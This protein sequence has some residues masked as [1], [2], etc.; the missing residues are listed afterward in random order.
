MTHPWPELVWWNSGERQV[1]E[2]KIHDLER[3]GTICNPK[4]KLLY[5]ALRVTPFR[6]CR[7]AIIGQDPYPSAEMA[8]GVAFS[9]PKDVTA[10]RF[11]QTLRII[12]G[13][14]QSDL[15]YQEPSCGD[16]SAWTRQGALL[17]NAVPSC[18]SGRPLS[19][20]WDEWRYLTGEIAERLNER[21]GTVF[22]FLGTVAASYSDKINLDTNRVIKTS[23]PSPRG[24]Q[25]GKTPFTGSR[26]FSTINAKLKEL[27]LQPI[28]WELTDEPPRKGNI[29]TAVV[30]RGRVLPNIT[31]AQLGGLK[32]TATSPNI[33]TSLA[34]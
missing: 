24:N 14:L 34:F 31:G 15:H 28:S 6:D 12:L 30:D 21:G 18:Q 32:R 27:D 26:V 33:Y 9:I 4:R 25:F 2:E 17:W 5:E 8:T 10:E 23:H 20:N 13:E 7:V 19:N 29:Q 11:P 1:V 22:V 3:A 16:L